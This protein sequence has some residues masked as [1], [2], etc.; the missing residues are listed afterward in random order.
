VQYKLTYETETDDNK[1]IRVLAQKQ[2][3]AAVKQVL[4]QL[5]KDLKAGKRETSSISPTLVLSPLT[6]TSP[7]LEH[8]KN[9]LLPTAKQAAGATSPPPTG[10]PSAN[11]EQGASA[12]TQAKEQKPK[13]KSDLKTI[14]MTIELLASGHDV[15]EALMDPQKVQQW[16]RAKAQ[17]SKQPGSPFVLFEGAISGE[18]VSVVQDKKIEQK[19]RLKD[20]PQGLLLLPIH[21]S[22]LP[23][24]NSPSPSRRSLL[25]CDNGA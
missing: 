14:K 25:A 4:E 15:F 10:T 13:P 23:E 19:W 8:E 6:S 21:R 3:L 16:T 20:W 7:S 17:I 5:K 24:L 11:K 22:L 9:V 2:F 18:V 12:P 1:S